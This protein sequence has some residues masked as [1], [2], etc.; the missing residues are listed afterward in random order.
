MPHPPGPPLH[1]RYCCRH[2]PAAPCQV[3]ALRI[4]RF[5][6][7][8][9]PLSLLCTRARERTPRLATLNQQ[10]RMEGGQTPTF[11]SPPVESSEVPSARLIRGS[12]QDQGPLPHQLPTPSQTLIF[13]GFPAFS[14]LSFPGS[15][16]VSL[17]SLPQLNHLHAG[18]SSS[19]FRPQTGLSWCPAPGELM[20]FSLP[21]LFSPRT[22]SSALIYCLLDSRATTFPR[23][24]KPFLFIQ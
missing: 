22:Q 14:V 18:V 11:A 1:S 3:S 4:P 5:L 7:T 20:I 10:G 24:A 8:R 13:T 9:S 23:G 19:A 2:T 6:S 15:C 21:L 17:E 12:Q 16:S